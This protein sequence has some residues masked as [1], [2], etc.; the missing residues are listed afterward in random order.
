MRIMKSEKI[1]RQHLRKNGIIKYN[2]QR[3]P[4]MI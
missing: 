1:R 4:E 3:G 2:G